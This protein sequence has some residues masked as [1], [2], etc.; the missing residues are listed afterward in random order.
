MSGAARPG[1]DSLLMCGTVKGVGAES[2]VFEKSYYCI[3]SLEFCIWSPSFEPRKFHV[4]R[5]SVCLDYIFSI[6]S[7]RFSDLKLE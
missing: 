7:Q 5:P 2:T 1:D 4:V 3:I 6:P